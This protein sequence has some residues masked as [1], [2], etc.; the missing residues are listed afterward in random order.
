M[1]P[2]SMFKLGSYI[3]ILSVALEAT[4]HKKLKRNVF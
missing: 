3:F 4:E 1:K 2:F